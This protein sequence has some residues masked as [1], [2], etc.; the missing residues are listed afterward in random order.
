MAKPLTKRPVLHLPLSASEKIIEVA[1]GIGILATI[2]LLY[3]PALPD[4]IPSH[5]NVAGQP[6]T[7][8]DKSL[9]WIMVAIPVVIYLAMTLLSRFPQIFNYPFTLTEENVERQYRCVRLLVSILKLEI[10]WFFAYLEW[11]IIQTAFGR[12]QGLGPALK[13]VLLTGLIGTVAV[14]LYRAGKLR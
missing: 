6:D 13:P 8:G 11:R 5:F 3:R 2:L 7:W 9:L 12:A 4:S 10:V 14:Y 1:A